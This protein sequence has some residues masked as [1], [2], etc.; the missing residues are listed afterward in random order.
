ME[1]QIYEIE[2]AAVEYRGYIYFCQ[3][4]TNAFF[5]INVE[6]EK[7][8]FLC[9][10]HTEKKDEGYRS[11][12]RY[13]NYAW[14]I[15]WQAEA[16]LCVDLETFH[17]E[18]YDIP[19][20]KKNDKGLTT[21]PFAYFHSSGRIN[22]EEIF[23]VPT[24]TDTAVIINMKERDIKAH[25][26][27]IDVENEV[28]WYG[29][30]V[31][32]NIWMAPYEGKRLII[33]DYKTG[34]VK[35]LPWKYES[36]QYSGML[37]WN[38]KIWFAPNKADN[39]LVYDLETKEYEKISMGECYNPDY[40]YLEIKYYDGKIW[41]LSWWSNNILLYDPEKKEWSSIAKDSE[42]CFFYATEFRNIEYEGEFA[43]VTCRTGYISIYDKVNKRFKNIF[44]EIDKDDICKKI[45]AN[46]EEL[47][48]IEKTFRGEAYYDADRY[49][50]LDNFIKVCTLKSANEK[51]EIVKTGIG[52][53][54]WKELKN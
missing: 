31:G 34:E 53:K 29:T 6:S 36:M 51:D 38:N 27:I 45:G 42:I 41:I 20:A 2:A 5:R 25:K 19:Y 48:V 39:M 7:T 54:I 18:Y 52:E 13:K 4:Q 14:Y 30:C 23:L 49:L 21:Y 33:M 24:G 1:R 10:L 17:M 3:P 32:D 26:G 44:V 12:F 11:A 35:S 9:F 8:E 37:Y 46:E 43:F 28:M 47:K 16:I 15:P 40:T 50:G 22:E